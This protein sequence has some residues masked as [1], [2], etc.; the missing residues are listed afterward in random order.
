MAADAQYPIWCNSRYPNGTGYDCRDLDSNRTGAAVYV[1]SGSGAGQMR[2]VTGGGTA[3]NRSWIIDRPF[4]GSGGGVPIAEDSIVSFLER[5][6]H[7]II[8]ENVFQDGGPCQIFG[9]LYHAVIAENTGA[10][11]YNRPCAQ[12]YVG[13]S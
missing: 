2:V 7:M 11:Q 6:S 10:W 3:F 4:G 5:R 12:Q 1:L 8:R 13:Q 9:G